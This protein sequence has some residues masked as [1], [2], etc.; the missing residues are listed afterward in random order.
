M[1]ELSKVLITQQDDAT[2]PRAQ[3]SQTQRRF[4]GKSQRSATRKTCKQFFQAE[5]FKQPDVPQ[6][7]RRNSQ[8]TESDSRK[9]A[10]REDPGLSKLRG[11]NELNL[12]PK[13]FPA[14]TFEAPA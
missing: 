13:F 11:R 14:K 4:S 12:T 8:L 3:S 2:L 7:G 9:Q 10:I 1:T 6:L 5:N